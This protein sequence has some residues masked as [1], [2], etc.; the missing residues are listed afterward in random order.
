M[1]LTT[2]TGL[3]NCIKSCTGPSLAI[4][5]ESSVLHALFPRM[6][7]F[8]CLLLTVIGLA[9]VHSNPRPTVQL[10][11]DCT[12]GLPGPPGEEGPCGPPGNPG[13]GTPGTPGATGPAGKHCVKNYIHCG[14][15]VTPKTNF[16]AIKKHRQRIGHLEFEY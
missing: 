2:V 13:V 7:L 5:S 1:T 10:S 16:F 6:R 4:S 9:G 3:C 12:P 15:L 11:K 8:S 14:G